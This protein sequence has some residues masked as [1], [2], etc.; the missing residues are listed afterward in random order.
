[1]VGGGTAGC[2]VATRLSQAATGSV[3][4][5]EAG[6]ARQPFASCVPLLFNTLKKHARADWG[7]VSEPELGAAGRRFLRSHGRGLGGSSAINGMI[8]VRGHP[9]DYDAWAALGL[10]GWSYAELLPYFRRSET[11]W[12]GA[13]HEHGAA[14]PWRVGPG[15]RAD[16]L[17]GLLAATARAAGRAVIDDFTGND[18]EGIGAPDFAIA[19]GMRMS[20]SRAYLAHAGRNLSILT[21]THVCRVLVE[22]GRAA[23]VELRQGDVT[24]RIFADCEVIVAAG[25]YNSPQL[26]LLSGIGDPDA[27]RH[28]GIDPVHDLPG[29]G[30][31]LQGHVAVPL[32]FRAKDIPGFH[33]ALRFD[34]IAASALQWG[35]SRR[36]LF[37]RVPL[38]ALSYVRSRDELDRPDIQIM[39]S[40]G[41]M[42]DYPWFPMLRP[43]IG[44]FIS[45]SISLCRPQ[46]RGD[47]T[48]RSASPFDAP[49]IRY[50]LL[51]VT[52]DL[53]RLR[54]ALRRE[55]AFYA[56]APLADVL[57]E[58]DVPGRDYR[59]DDALDAR[60]REV[61]TSGQHPTSTCAMGSDRQTV[62]DAELR[63]HGLTGLRVADA[64][65]MPLIPSGN[66]Y[67][68]VVMIAEK[69]ADLVLGKTAI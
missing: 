68:T 17:F 58:E 26:L 64:S 62:V 47:V 12:R 50:N 48:L 20:T 15:Y 32:R 7:Y 49:R 66:T 30:R 21:D 35:L 1:V 19:D 11:N 41:R 63:V 8:A 67:A 42:D 3:L 51:D 34:R 44:H 6:P 56:T 28:V 61:A 43:G 13:S 29:V 24:R 65:I 55:R 59:S 40:T 54:D 31:N 53:A 39:Y 18:Q 10:P 33:R 9:R 45:S 14:G 5:I 38:T 27:L 16:P 37:G 2:V 69:A 23:G 22:E 57:V 36:G 46:S 60:L 4:L 52:D 25:A